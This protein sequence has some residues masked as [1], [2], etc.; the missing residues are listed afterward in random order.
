MPQGTNIV[1]QI[2][3]ET[4]T[5]LYAMLL[6]PLRFRKYEQMYSNINEHENIA[7]SLNIASYMETEGSIIKF[8]LNPKILL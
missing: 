1:W 2:T 3:Y 6:H 5:Y 4:F 8:D 7:I